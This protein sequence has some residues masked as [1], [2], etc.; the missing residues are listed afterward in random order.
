MA[1]TTTARATP[2]SP[3]NIDCT[4][5]EIILKAIISGSIVLP[6]LSSKL[7][8]ATVVGNWPLHLLRSV[9]LTG[10][11]CRSNH[12][13]DSNNPLI[14]IYSLPANIQPQVRS[15]TITIISMNIL[16]RI[17]NANVCP[18]PVL[19]MHKITILHS[20]RHEVLDL[21]LRVDLSQLL[22][23]FRVALLWFL[24]GN[25]SLETLVALRRCF[26]RCQ[27]ACGRRGYT[28]VSFHYDGAT[29]DWTMGFLLSL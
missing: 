2:P 6:L 29:T 12:K 26:L 3:S 11:I 19:Y 7:S 13:N 1:A 22:A 8:S 16:N 18:T 15:N 24:W 4:F 20:S 23:R 5:P 28:G 17:P 14:P 21:L 25:T 10:S 27:F 9:G